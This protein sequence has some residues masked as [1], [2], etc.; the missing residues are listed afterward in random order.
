MNIHEVKLPVNCNKRIYKESFLELF[1][2]RKEEMSQNGGIPI[3]FGDERTSSLIDLRKKIGVVSDIEE[4]DDMLIGHV[5]LHDPDV[6]YG[7]ATVLN[8]IKNGAP[9]EINPR[10]IGHKDDGTFTPIK[11]ICFD[12]GIHNFCKRNL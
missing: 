1:N 8:L 12:F 10:L 2:K 6:N 7:A 4:I 5:S 9:I 3:T 11:L